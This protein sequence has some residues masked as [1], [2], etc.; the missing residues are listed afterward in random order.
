MET[1]T[2]TAAFI[3]ARIFCWCAL[4]ARLWKYQQQQN[5]WCYG[6]LLIIHSNNIENDL[7]TPT[8]RVLLLRPCNVIIPYNLDIWYTAFPPM[9]FFLPFPFVDVPSQVNYLNFSERESARNCCLKLMSHW[10]CLYYNCLRTCFLPHAHVI[11]PTLMRSI[12]RL[13]MVTW[14]VDV[15]CCFCVS[16]DFGSVILG[17]LWFVDSDH[18]GVHGKNWKTFSLFFWRK[19]QALCLPI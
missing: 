7:T 8:M 9:F 17:G 15:L 18:L 5:S 13:Y 19:W 12:G 4:M 11:F 14:S 1:C 16:P 10:T 2:C 6:F 3:S